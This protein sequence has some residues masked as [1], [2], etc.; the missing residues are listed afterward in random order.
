MPATVICL[1]AVCLTTAC[2]SIQHLSDKHQKETV[3]NIPYVVMNN[4]FLKSNVVGISYPLITKQEEFSGLFG[5]AAVMGKDG[6]PTSID[7]SKESVIAIVL[8]ET[9]VSTEIIPL[10][11]EK[12]A[13]QGL[14]MYYTVKRGE[15][16]MSTMRPILLVKIKTNTARKS[17]PLR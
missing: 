2:R 4:Y 3:M 16:M 6:A 1:A 13:A 9:N 12:G 10:R 11:L 8:P 15:E 14:R 5:M 7:F 17:C